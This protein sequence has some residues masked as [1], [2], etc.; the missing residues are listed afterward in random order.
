MEQDSQQRCHDEKHPHVADYAYVSQLH[1]AG[2]DPAQ[3]GERQHSAGKHQ[4]AD[5][6]R[7]ATPSEDRGGEQHREREED[8]PGQDVE[9][10]CNGWPVEREDQ[11]HP[12]LPGQLGMAAQGQDH[13]VQAARHPGKQAHED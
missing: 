10:V 12:R 7:Q 3:A 4:C 9:G 5:P 1:V 8:V 6:C 11:R 13:E 2:H